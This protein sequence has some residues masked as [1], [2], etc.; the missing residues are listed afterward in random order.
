MSSRALCPGYIHQRAPE[1]AERW[2]PARRTSDFV[3]P[4]PLVPGGH[5]NAGNFA[6]L[7]EVLGHFAPNIWPRWEY[8]QVIAVLIT[9]IN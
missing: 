5:G 8:V 1:Q 4:A 6:R 3:I 7:G 2:L 9:I